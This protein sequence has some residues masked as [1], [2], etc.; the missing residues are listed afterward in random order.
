VGNGKS[1]TTSLTQMFGA[2][3]AAHEIDRARIRAVAAK[4]L[5]GEL[6]E[7]SARVRAELV[8]RSVRYHLE[9]DV[10]GHMAVFA[11]TLAHMYDDLKFVLLIRDCFSWLDSVV[12]QR[13]RALQAG[14]AWDALD[15]SKYF[16][17]G[18]SFTRAEAPLEEAGLI[19]IAAW[20]R[21]WAANNERV[22][23]SV[24]PARLLV[25]RT[26]DL[27]DSVEALAHFAGVPVP[28]VRPAHA[29]RHPSRTGL[30]GAVPAEYVVER[31][32]EH[33]GSL[34]ER[35]WGPDWY[36]LRSRLPQRA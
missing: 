36:E 35:F 34:M 3:R 30:L 33:C 17:Y 2:Y 15:H 32:H 8:R 18:E 7:R 28:T 4:V 1:G 21:G 19:P 27:D 29:N 13:V 5:N 11:G 25:V 12:E 6:D 20:L 22:L 24:A 14:V 10:A 16:R 31:A 23:G 26:E 9:V